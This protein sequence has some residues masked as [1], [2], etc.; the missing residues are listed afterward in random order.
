VKSLAEQ[1]IRLVMSTVAVAP[2]EDLGPGNYSYVTYVN[3]AS[4]L[5]IIEGRKCAEC[6]EMTWL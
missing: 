5:L 2:G 1:F 6:M 3:H 4:G